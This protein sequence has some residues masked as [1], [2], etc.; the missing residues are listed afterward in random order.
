[1][2]ASTSSDKDASWHSDYLDVSDDGAADVWSEGAGATWRH[3]AI[4]IAPAGGLTFWLNGQKA[5]KIDA[6]PRRSLFPSST[7]ASPTPAASA[8]PAP[9]TP[10]PGCV[11]AL[12]PG[13]GECLPARAFRSAA[14]E[15]RYRRFPD[16]YVPQCLRLSRPARA[17]IRRCG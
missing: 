1:M 12:L 11:P 8:V 5:D 9:A 7:P 17:D 4:Q 16:L 13:C 15:W 6:T 14:G 3:I 10:F 2:Y